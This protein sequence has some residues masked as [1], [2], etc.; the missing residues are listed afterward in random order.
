MD[1]TNAKVRVVPIFF[2]LG[3]AL[4]V[5]S[6]FLPAFGDTGTG[7]ATFRGWECAVVTFRNFP[8]WFFLPFLVN[9][10]AIF[11]F[12]AKVLGRLP[13]LRLCSA[14]ATLALFVPTWLALR[15]AVILLGCAMWVV[16]VLLMMSE[17]LGSW[18]LK[19]L[20]A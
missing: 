14:I 4:F 5:T 8:K 7:G 3:I 13:R 11:F 12:F 18:K 20:G 2:Y 1:E 15:D 6:F 19:L 16:S 9:P 17:D 10:L